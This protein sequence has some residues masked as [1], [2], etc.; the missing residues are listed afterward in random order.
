MSQF[1]TNGR[2]WRVEAEVGGGFNKPVL[3]HILNHVLYMPGHVPSYVLKHMPTRHVPEY[4]LKH[5]L[6]HVPDKHMLE[7]GPGHMPRQQA[8]SRA[9]ENGASCSKDLATAH[10]RLAHAVPIS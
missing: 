1:G 3:G 2:R 4:V 6:R 7:H 8:Q 10:Y 9:Q 5:V